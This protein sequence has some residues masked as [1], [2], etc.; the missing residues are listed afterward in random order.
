ML[1]E[2]EEEENPHPGL[3]RASTFTEEQAFKDRQR[4]TKRGLSREQSRRSSSRSREGSVLSSKDS[5]GSGRVH[6]SPTVVEEG[7]LHVVVSYNRYH[8]LL[9]LL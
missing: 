9:L 4:W 5:R 6:P 7:L 3:Y 8:Q 1:P 2:E